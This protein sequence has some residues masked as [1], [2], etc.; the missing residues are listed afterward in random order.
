MNRQ[1]IRS[2]SALLRTIVAVASLGIC[3]SSAAAEEPHTVLNDFSSGPD[4]WQIYDYDGGIAGGGNAFFPVTWE[5]SG[6]V[7]DS[8]YI[9]GDDSRWRIDTPEKPNSILAFIIYRAWV[10]GG[11]LD[12]RNAEVSV[13]LRGDNLDLKG[14]KCLFWALDNQNGTRWHYTARPLEIEE[15]RW[16]DK[17]TF[18]LKD[19]ESLWHRSWSRNPKNPASLAEVLRGCDSYGLSFV[20]FSGEVTGK[21]SM[22]ELRIKLKPGTERR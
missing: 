12:L 19:D 10:K 16:R 21:L 17:Q 8:G 11:E 22:D 6:G 15:G 3:L 9:W 2:H 14:A 5:K 13:C 1:A 18:V 20:G 4:G 7:E